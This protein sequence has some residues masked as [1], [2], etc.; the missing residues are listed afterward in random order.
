[1]DLDRK[2]PGILQEEAFDVNGLHRADVDVDGYADVLEIGKPRITIV[3]HK[4]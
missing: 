3:Y 1:L 4:R 2:P